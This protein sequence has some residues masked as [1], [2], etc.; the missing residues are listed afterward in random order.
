MADYLYDAQGLPKGFRLGAYIYALDGAA[1]GRVWAEKAYRL[2]GTYVGAVVKNMIVDKAS[3]SRRNMP[4]I[5]D[6]GPAQPPAGGAE[7]RRP[8]GD[9]VVDVFHLLLEPAEV[10]ATDPPDPSW[11]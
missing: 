3:V 10:A 9:N 5:A 2:D 6:P 4:P 1:I 7:S 8:V 11:P